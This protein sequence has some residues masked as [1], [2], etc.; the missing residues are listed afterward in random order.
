[1]NSIII[2][3]EPNKNLWK[4]LDITYGINETP[5]GK[6]VL[7]KSRKGICFL[8]FIKDSQ[9]EIT[10]KLFKKWAKASLIRDDKYTE[11]IVQQIFHS[12]TD[13][14]FKLHISGTYF[15]LKVWDFLL[16]IPEKCLMSYSEVAKAI[17]FPKTARAVGN[18]VGQNPVHYLIPCH[19][20]IRK[21]GLLGGYSG[22]VTIKQAILNTQRQNIYTPENH[23]NSRYS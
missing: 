10:A 19:K 2:V 6:A 7:A 22:G 8:H 3:K 18:A 16:K 11:V 1:M 15:Q 13:N 12:N 4:S 23:G 21:D 14:T 9:E 5:Y 17:G 20:V